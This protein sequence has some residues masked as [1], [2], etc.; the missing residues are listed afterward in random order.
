LKQ[1]SFDTPLVKRKRD[2]TAEMRGVLGIPTVT[3]VRSILVV[4]VSLPG[5]AQECTLSSVKWHLHEQQFNLNAWFQKTTGGRV[6]FNNDLDKNGIFDIAEG[7][8]CLFVLVIGV[9]IFFFGKVTLP[10]QSS[11]T[12]MVIAARDAVV[13]QGIFNRCQNICF[14]VFVLSFQNQHSVR[15]LPGCYA[16][17]K[18]G[19]RSGVRH[20][21]MRHLQRLR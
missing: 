7:W 20:G 19:L 3:G 1:W 15:S 10:L 8:L 4:L 13:T 11:C 5:V 6:Q 9:F 21:G 18:H 16:L 12:E 14:R 17:F 2:I